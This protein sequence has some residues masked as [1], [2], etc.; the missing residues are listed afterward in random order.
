MRSTAPAVVLF[1][2]SAIVLAAPSE[3]VTCLIILSNSPLDADFP[4]CKNAVDAS[5]PKILAYAPSLSLLPIFKVA[6]SNSFKIVG[7]SLK[8]PLASATET[9]SAF[10]SFAAFLGATASRIKPIRKAVPACVPLI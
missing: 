1:M 7:I 2:V 8:L 6:L 4:N 9:P 10:N 3:S 5:T